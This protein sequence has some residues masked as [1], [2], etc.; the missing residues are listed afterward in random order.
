MS[1]ATAVHVV[2]A[3]CGTTNRVAED[4]LRHEVACGRC[5]AD[6]LAAEPFALTDE[7]FDHYV[8]RTE[9]P[10]LVDFWAE[11]CGPCR[12]MAPQFA[13]AAARAPEVR[14]AKVDTEANPK[15]SVRYRI[16]SIPTLV[17]LRGGEEIAR[18]SGAMSAADLERWVRSQLAS[19]TG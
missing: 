19:R 11:W 10:V 6:L 13:A 12:M 8:G 4:K 18:A 7:N 9:L 2:C 15:T 5:G 17:L 14:F 1:T 3:R 16:R